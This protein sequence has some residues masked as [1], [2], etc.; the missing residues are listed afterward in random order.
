MSTINLLGNFVVYVIHCLP[1]LA[2]YLQAVFHVSNFFGKLNKL[3]T[4]QV[5]VWYKYHVQNM[6]LFVYNIVQ[7]KKATNKPLLNKTKE[8]P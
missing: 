4:K 8:L 3:E 7:V 1:R 5:V 2:R 6:L